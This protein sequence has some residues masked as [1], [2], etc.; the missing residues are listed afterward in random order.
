[1]KHKVEPSELGFVAKALV[2][3]GMLK[4]KGPASK[5]PVFL[6][7]DST[8]AYGKYLAN[9]I[10]NCRGCHIAMDEQANQLNEDFAGGGVFLPNAFSKGYAFV[11]PN[12]TPHKGTGR[13]AEWSEQQFIDRFRGGRLYDG[14]PMPW[15]LYSRMSETDL[16]AL[17][18]YLHSL[19]P[20]EYNVEKT[21]YEPGEKLPQ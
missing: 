14:S 17:Y 1:V 5:P 7:E 19:E 21:V 15:G 9:N 2:T 6:T 10:G 11:S 20:V 8:A 13:I 4:P 12:L 16:K 3:F 18:R